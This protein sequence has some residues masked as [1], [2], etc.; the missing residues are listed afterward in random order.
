MNKTMRNV[1]YIMIIIICIV[2]IFVGV[3][4]QFFKKVSDNDIDYN[5]ISGN[6]SSNN[7]SIEEIKN[8]FKDLFT[9]E[10]FSFDYNEE[11]IEKVD[12]TKPIVY[13]GLEFNQQEEDKYKI[14]ATLPFLNITGTVADNYNNLTQK[15]FVDKLSNIIQN[16]EV[17]TICDMSYT[18]YVNNDILSIAIM[19]SIKEGD[20]AQRI[21]IQT[22]NYNILTNEDVLISDIIKLR[23]LD[24]NTINK[25]IKSVVK[26]AADDAQSMQNTGY[27]IYD[28][29]VDSDKY[30]VDNVEN[31]DVQRYGEKI[32]VNQVFPK[33]TNVEFAEILN[34]QNIKM[35]V[36]ERGTGETLACGTGACATAVACSLNNL[37]DR[38]VFV[39]LLRWNFG[40]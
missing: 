33:K 5:I 1:L 39:E 40:N 30:D 12:T 34:G 19:A 36:W 20:N 29:D 23:D 24:K 13:N 22:Y 38:H 31:F 28:R 7:T 26:K 2:A 8:S 17:Y 27:N 6:V 37:T 35:R 3:Y 18:A 16:S 25:K 32:E 10:Y 21:M 9:N 4:A 15:I 11:N 14:Q